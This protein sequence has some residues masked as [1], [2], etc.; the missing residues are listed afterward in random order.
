MAD[1]LIRIAS[2]GVRQIERKYL[3]RALERDIN[4]E[5][6]QGMAR[7]G[8]D[9]MY[10]LQ[11]TAPFRTGRLSD[12]IKVS[13]V[14][15]SVRRPAVEVSVAA[16]DDKGFDYLN[17]TRF[18][19]RAVHAKNYRPGFRED[20]GR[21]AS[22]LSRT[23]A[24]GSGQRRPFRRITLGFEPGPP[25][26]GDIYRHS[27]RAWKPRGDWVKRSFPEVEKAAQEE[28][29]KITDWVNYYMNDSPKPSAPRVP[30]IRRTNRHG[31]L[32]S[33]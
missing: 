2:T 31:S 5:I 16:V 8:D 1:M 19:R 25:G 7:L 28:M 27:V 10:A 11:N 22:R 26:S 15:A 18:G 12:N 30:V 33:G 13:K 24:T 6:K 29:E 9:A 3:I 4:R 23:P 21:G 20:A 14:S 32:R 17:V